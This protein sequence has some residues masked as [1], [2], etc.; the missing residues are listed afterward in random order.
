MKIEGELSNFEHPIMK[1]ASLCVAEEDCLDLEFRSFL[2]SF[3]SSPFL[4][5]SIFNFF[6]KTSEKK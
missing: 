3:P 5:N 1:R 6:K 2:L 4:F